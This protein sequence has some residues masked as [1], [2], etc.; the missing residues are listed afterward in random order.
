MK[1]K[2]VSGIMLTLLLTSAFAVLFNPVP[3]A[4]GSPQVLFEE[5]FE[6]YVV[7]SFP[8]DKFYAHWGGWSVTQEDA[9]KFL[10]SESYSGA[11]YLL[12]TQ[13]KFPGNTTIELL[14]R[15]DASGV[16]SG[17]PAIR[18][19]N[20]PIP[21]VIFPGYFGVHT[22]VWSNK[23]WVDWEYSADGVS[24]ETGMVDLGQ[25]T[26]PIQPGLWYKI[27]DVLNGKYVSFYIDDS[28]IFEY[29]VSSLPF[30]IDDFFV[31]WTT[32]GQKDIDNIK[33]STLPPTHTLAINSSPTGV[34]FTV[35]GVSRTTPWSG[36]YS[37]GA[38]VSLVMPETHDGYVWSH[39]QEDGDPNRIKA[40]TMDT[41]ITLTGVYAPAPK[42]VG[43]K[44]TP[45]NIPIN[46][47]ELPALWV[48]LSTIIFPLVA[49]ALYVKRRK[50]K[51]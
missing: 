40:V 17:F 3:K 32:W 50:K 22:S 4:L 6:S 36:T 42:P 38:S 39:W 30:V 8:S 12:R 45:I 37:E 23:A 5:D 9:N 16:A 47:P 41:N 25:I 46:K 48:W 2:A 1:L 14:Y 20:N 21:Q 34:A 26:I 19:D 27:K 35:D 29:D 15:A 44:A 31:T 13:Q 33:V 43:G 24:C 28:L 18:L 49:T 7:G 10:R 51:Q 11:D